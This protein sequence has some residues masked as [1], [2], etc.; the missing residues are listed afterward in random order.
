MCQQVLTG[1]FWKKKKNKQDYQVFSLGGFF[2]VF[3]P[4]PF[5][6]PFTLSIS[7]YLRED[8]LSYALVQMKLSNLQSFIE[9]QM[10]P[11]KLAC[12]WLT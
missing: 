9:Y 11:S 12:L 5:L 3:F 10:M 8:K 6:S 2:L 7:L 4:S 1:D